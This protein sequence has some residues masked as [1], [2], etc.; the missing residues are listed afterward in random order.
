MDYKTRKS[1][2]LDSTTAHVR[3]WEVETMMDELMDRSVSLSN[4]P[5]NK[6][7][8]NGKHNSIQLS[9]S[10]PPLNPRDQYTAMQ[11]ECFLLFTSSTSDGGPGSWHP[12]KLPQRPGPD[13]GTLVLLS[14][15][16]SI[17][18]G[19]ASFHTLYLNTT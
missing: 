10:I 16:F 18:R 19:D 17:S 13:E 6:G 15:D 3:R 11:G 2:H 1:H 8:T 9:T 12:R 4:D 5:D 14:I 7:R